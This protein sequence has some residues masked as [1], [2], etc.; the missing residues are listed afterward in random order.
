MKKYVLKFLLCLCLVIPC[1]IALGACNNEEPPVTNE[2]TVSF[3]N[4]SKIDDTTYS[5]KVSNVTETINFSD[6]V[7]ITGDAQWALTTDIQ[8]K[9]SIPSKIGTLEIG[10]NVYYVLVTD[11][12]SNVKLY[13]LQIRRKPMYQVSFNTLGGSSVQ[14]KFVEEGALLT[15]DMATPTREDSTFSHWNF[16]FNTPI[17]E[18][19]TINAVYDTVKYS[20]TY[21]L[22]GGNNNQ[23]NPLE[24][25]KDDVFPIQLKA[26]S[27]ED[28]TVHFDGWF[29]NPNFSGEPVTQIDYDREN[30]TLYAYWETAT[31]GLVYR[32]YGSY[33]AVYDYEGTETD[34]VIGQTRFDKPV[35]TIGF[36][37]FQNNTTIK[38]IYI[39]KN[40]ESMGN[41][42]FDGCTNLE[43]IVFEE[44]SPIEQFGQ[45]TFNGCTRL[46]SIE[47]IPTG[48]T[49]IGKLVFEDC[50][51]L[52]F[53]TYNGSKYF[54]DDNNPYLILMSQAIS[55]ASIHSSTKFIYSYSINYAGESLVI[56]KNVV[57]ICAYAN[58]S[59]GLK[60]I[61]FE[62]NSVLSVIGAYAFNN[63]NIESISLPSSLKIIEE[64]AFSDCEALSNVIFA[65]EGVNL[66]INDRAFKNCVA[67]EKVFIPNYVSTISASIQASNSPFYGCS[68]DLILY[69]EHNEK[70]A[71]WSSYWNYYAAYSPLNVYWG[72]GSIQ[73][74]SDESHYY[75]SEPTFEWVE[76][77]SEFIVVATFVCGC[78][79][80][81]KTD[82]TTVSSSNY[83][84]YENSSQTEIT[85]A[86]TATIDFEGKEYTDTRYIKYEWKTVSLNNSNYKEYLSVGCSYTSYYVYT[87]VAK[88]D[89]NLTYSNVSVTFTVSLKGNA[90]NGASSMG[91]S[92][93]ET[94]VSGI[95]NKTTSVLSTGI[96]GYYF[97]PSS[98]TYSVSVSGQVSGYFLTEYLV[99]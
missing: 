39:P 43:T 32:D 2:V 19:I 76:D 8:G 63:S 61:S 75:L 1:L 16:D 86:F 33:Y 58:V 67:L 99:S 84:V 98:L 6:I 79:Q 73:G 85:F 68:S 11:T 18:P 55:D 78:G 41:Y 62:N 23:E 52:Q 95:E 57:Q 66:T 53:S 59:F 24:Y 80:S 37:V 65:E 45:A 21:V 49:Y 47:N 60:N 5:Y 40:I 69:C 56:P 27:N 22:N 93:T 36:G 25:S 71:S 30:I 15:N 17:T 64:E 34:I 48:L 50:F 13:T 89:S 51:G 81:T 7:S 20:I 44:N 74:C 82:E 97:Y 72:C 91:Y 42:V 31:E 94:I 83:E 4:F 26:P 70:P 96:S 88:K 54:G 38:S 87:G 3:E 35:K 9:D 14:S 46:R 10:D 29:T 12:S 90:N 77:D 28:S 92:K